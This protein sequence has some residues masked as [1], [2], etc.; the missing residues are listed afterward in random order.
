[1]EYATKTRLTGILS[2]L[3]TTLPVQ[4]YDLT[5]DYGWLGIDCLADVTNFRKLFTKAV[6]LA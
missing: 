5:I 2:K 1:M 3:R 6:S 4:G